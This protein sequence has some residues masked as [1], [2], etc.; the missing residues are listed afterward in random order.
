MN[1]NYF[2]QTDSLDTSCGVMVS[3]LDRQIIT[4]EFESH[5]VSHVTC[6]LCHSS[7]N[8]SKYPQADSL[9]ISLWPRILYKKKTKKKKP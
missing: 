4:S 7:A 3:K 6:I 9:V 2:L 8:L 5:W 1:P